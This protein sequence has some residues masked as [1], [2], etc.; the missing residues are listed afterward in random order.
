MKKDLY[1]I[2]NELGVTWLKLIKNPNI[3]Q[4][5]MF[6]ID[7]TLLTTS[8]KKIKSIIDLLNFAK[9]Q[10]FIV[11]IITARE[12][13]GTNFT[14]KQLHENGIN[15]DRLY[16]RPVGQD[17][18]TFKTKLKEFIYKKYHFPFV[19]SIG[20]QWLDVR[21]DYSGYSIKLPDTVD[22]KLHFLNPN[23]SQWEYII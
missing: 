22:P 1:Q 8:G 11:I 4:A 23:N 21:G 6:D 15:Y 13:P 19:M 17:P 14:I 16:L 2:A 10:G 3:H 5:V 20:D 7:D 9:R 12:E 18:Y